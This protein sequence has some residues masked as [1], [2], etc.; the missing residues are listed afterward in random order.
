MKRVCL[1]W[2]ILVLMLGFVCF[3]IAEPNPKTETTTTWASIKSDGVVTVKA[4]P[5]KSVTMVPRDYATIQ[6]AI[7]E[8]D[9]GDTIK[10]AA[11]EY[12]GAEIDK[13]VSLIGANSVITNLPGTPRIQPHLPAGFKLIDGAD[14]TSIRGFVFDGKDFAEKLGESW[15]DAPDV[16]ALAVY[17]KSV[18]NVV[19]EHN[20]VLGT[21]QGISNWYGNG[22]V[23]SHNDV[24][25]QG[26]RNGGGLGILVGSSMLSQ[27]EPV[28]GN[29]IEYNRVTGTINADFP[30]NYSMAGIVLFGVVGTVVRNNKVAFV[31]ECSVEELGI[32]IS[33]TSIATMGRV[34]PLCVDTEVVNND[35]RDSEIGLVV[36]EGNSEGL[37]ARGN[38]GRNVIVDLDVDSSVKNRSPA[39]VFEGE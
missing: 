13:P 26:Y 36:D 6:E 35:C 17:S 3:A 22:W 28:S 38:F 34:W 39:S 9:P 1:A 25:E 7:D 5:K 27:G 2:M 31:N 16:L 12:A 14:G 18:D 10:V 11:G 32:G 30:G 23:I 15:P 33:V 19:I 24:V 4:A 8:A 21:M 37:F 29:V 20:T